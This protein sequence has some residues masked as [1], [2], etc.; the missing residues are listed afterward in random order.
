M[1]LNCYHYC[2]TLEE[3]MQAKL[4]NLL[5]PAGHFGENGQYAAV[6]ITRATA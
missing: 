2:N 4:E 1:A 3:I 5:F 6:C